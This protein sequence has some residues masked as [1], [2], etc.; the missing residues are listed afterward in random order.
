[1]GSSCSLDRRGKKEDQPIIF[2][3]NMASI[4]ETPSGKL[5]YFL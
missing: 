3:K 2:Q 1:M 4:E 5:P